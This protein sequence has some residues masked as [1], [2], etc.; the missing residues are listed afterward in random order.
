MGHET[1]Y[2]QPHRNL[3][4]NVIHSRHG[5]FIGTPTVFCAGVKNRTHKISDRN[6]LPCVPFTYILFT[7]ILSREIN[8]NQR[9]VKRRLASGAEVI[10]YRRRRAYI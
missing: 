1:G 5:I 2:Q 4:F 7:R 8:N 3:V 9:A 10:F 6:R